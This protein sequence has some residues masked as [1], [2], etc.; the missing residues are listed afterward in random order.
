MPGTQPL[1]AELWNRVAL[2][3]VRSLRCG[4]AAGR[5]L[6]LIA[7]GDATAE[8]CAVDLQRQLEHSISR[9][10][11]VVYGEDVEIVHEMR[12]A[13]R[14]LRAAIRVF[15][16]AFQG[17]LTQQKDRLEQLGD[18]LGTARDTDVFIDFL[19]Q[20]LKKCPKQCRPLILGVLAAENQRRGEEYGRVWEACRGRA[21]E[22][23]VG[24]MYAEVRRPLGAEGGLW[25]VKHGMSRR[26]PP[27]RKALAR[28]LRRLDRFGRR[29]EALSIGRQHE[30]RIACKKLR[31]TGE[32]LRRFIRPGSGSSWRR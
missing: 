9:R 14:R 10:F 24:R 18:L 22:E 5:L 12:V 7:P 13:T 17:K 28:E 11:G 2:R 19:Q 1:R 8:A 16:K 3:P 21:Y 15:G 4:P 29:V 31:Y 32:F 26:F 20:Y 30:L 27:R 23:S 6:P 25:A